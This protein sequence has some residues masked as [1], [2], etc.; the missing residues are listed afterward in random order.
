MELN[1]IDRLKNLE[2]NFIERKPEGVNKRDMRK[3]IV[4]FANSVSEGRVGILFIGVGNNGEI[5]GVTGT[6][7]IQKTVNDICKSDCYPPINIVSEVLDVGGKY[8]VAVKVPASNKRPHFSGPAYIRQ[9][10]ESSI[11]SEEI[12]NE[13]IATRLSKPYEILK[14]KDQLVTVIALGKKLGSTERLN[15]NRFRARY[16][17]RVLGC[18]PHHVD[19]YDIREQQYLTEPLDNTTLSKD[20]SKLGRLM[21]IVQEK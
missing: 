16:E 3:T 4:A 2:D 8:I 21:L 1:L 18:T 11:A 15:D 20:N 9:G 14:W 5:Q 7:S 13:L 12:F 19:L 6:D 10:S 17:C